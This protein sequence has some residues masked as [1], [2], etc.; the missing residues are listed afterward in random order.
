MPS[1]P[2]WVTALAGSDAGPA[3]RGPSARTRKCRVRPGASPSTLHDGAVEPVSDTRSDQLAPPS[4]DASTRYPLTTPAA[5]AVHA[6]S[7]RRA[8]AAVAASPVGAA[9]TDSTSTTVPVAVALCP[10]PASPA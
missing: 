8:P 5:G 3:P 9:G 2:W 6:R 7:T 4:A 1:T 10:D